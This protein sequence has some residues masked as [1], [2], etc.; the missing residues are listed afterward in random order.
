MGHDTQKIRKRNNMWLSYNADDEEY[1]LWDKKPIAATCTTGKYFYLHNDIAIARFTY[2]ERDDDEL[3]LCQFMTFPEMKDMTSIE[4]DSIIVNEKIYKSTKL[5][6]Y[7][8]KN[9][10]VK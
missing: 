10:F 7:Y 5:K 3:K 9:S 1:E 8:T 6:S 2:D 4:L